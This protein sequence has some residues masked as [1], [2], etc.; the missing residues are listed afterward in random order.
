MPLYLDFLPGEEVTVGEAKITV[1]EKTGRRVRLKFEADR[2]IPIKKGCD[3]KKETHG[4]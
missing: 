1:Q 4:S 3:S 2:S